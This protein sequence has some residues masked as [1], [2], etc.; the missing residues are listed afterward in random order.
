MRVKTHILTALQYSENTT[1]R[2]AAFQVPK[3]GA[4]PESRVSAPILLETHERHSRYWFFARA[5]QIHRFKSLSRSYCGAERRCVQLMRVQLTPT[6]GMF[7]RSRASSRR[8][9]YVLL[10]FLPFEHDTRKIVD[11]SCIGY[12]RRSAPDSSSGM[13]GK[14]SV[15]S[16][17]IRLAHLAHPGTKSEASRAVYSPL[18]KG[19]KSRSRFGSNRAEPKDDTRIQQRLPQGCRFG[20]LSGAILPLLVSSSTLASSYG[21]VR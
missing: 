17:R 10:P 16:V 20:I 15:G 5:Y 14:K 4:G 12:L 3:L 13:M 9:F 11:T 18:S 2:L 21:Q 7:F 19:S 6:P 1:G 8:M